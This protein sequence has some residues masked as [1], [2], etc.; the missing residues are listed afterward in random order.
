[1]SSPTGSDNTQPGT[2]PKKRILVLL[3]HGIRTQAEWQ[4][5]L[6]HLLENAGCVVVPLKYGY[7][8][9]F[10]FLIPLLFRWIPIREVR[11]VAP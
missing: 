8:D 9:A 6:S 7:F 5:W 11:V 1:M 2:L 4:G 10:S 3:I